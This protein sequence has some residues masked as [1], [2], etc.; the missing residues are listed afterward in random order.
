MVQ[1]YSNPQRRSSTCIVQISTNS[2]SELRYSFSN[3]QATNIV[4][5]KLAKNQM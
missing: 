5:S 3:Q 4:Q 1:C 2:K